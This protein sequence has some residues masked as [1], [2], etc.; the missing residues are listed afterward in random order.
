ME[1]DGTSDPFYKV[2]QE[3][4]V[5]PYVEIKLIDKFVENPILKEALLADERLKNISIL[6]FANATVFPIKEEEAMV[7]KTIRS[8]E[9]SQVPVMQEDAEKGDEIN[10]GVQ[11]WI[12]APGENA[13]K[14]EDFY[15]AGL[16]GIGW[17]QLGD[18]RQYTSREAVTAKLQELYGKENSYKNASLCIWQFANELKPGDIVFAKQGRKSCFRLYL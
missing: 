6:K 17:E 13:R 2:Q 1:K 18:L 3:N 8:G 14:W 11:Y 7:L 10:R 9:Y 15:A 12:Y 5:T 16:M 4:K